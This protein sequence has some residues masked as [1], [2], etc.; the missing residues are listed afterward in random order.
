MHEIGH[1]VDDFL[2]FNAKVLGEL[3]NK[4]I[5]SN[6]VSSKI[7]PKIFRKLKLQ[8][9]DIAEKLSD[10]GSTNAQETFAEAFSE[11]MSSPKPR[12]LANEYGK[13]I[14]EMFS[15]IEMEDSFKGL[16]SGN[17]TVVLEKDVRYRK[18]GNIKNTGYNNPV[19]LL[20]K[21][22]QKIVKNTYESAMVITE[23]GEIYV[24]KGDASSISLH[25]MSIPYKNSY[26]T[27]NHPEGLHEWGFSND[28]FTFFTNYELRY[29]AAI[30][31][32]YIH[33]LSRNMFEMKDIDLNMDPRKLENVNFE[34]VAEVFQVQKAKEKKLKYRRKRHVVK[35][36]QAL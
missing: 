15:K 31:E 2:S 17:K 18:L 7:R 3:P 23:S 9:G 22:E 24:A 14:D 36:T 27:H 33:E 21:Y 34:N 8:I 12:E 1:A 26:I 13:T 5:A 28:D 19:D 16:G 6:L 11:F 35:K 20:R 32:K 30:D 10:Y 4:N 29:M 25:K